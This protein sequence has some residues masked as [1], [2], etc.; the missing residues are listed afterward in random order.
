MF[1]W[2]IL[3]DLSRVA[4]TKTLS[5]LLLQLLL[6]VLSKSTGTLSIRVIRDG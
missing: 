6:E 4:A 5:S 2:N 1:K 3:L